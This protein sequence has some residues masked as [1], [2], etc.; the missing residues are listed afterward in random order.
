M[1]PLTQF[2]LERL[3]EE[4]SFKMSISEQTAHASSEWLDI[5]TNNANNLNRIE[6]SRGTFIDHENLSLLISEQKIIRTWPTQNWS[7]LM[8]DQTERFAIFEANDSYHMSI[9]DLESS[10]W[11]EDKEGHMLYFSD[12]GETVIDNFHSIIHAFPEE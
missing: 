9:L 3:I 6:L 1:K 8:I 11:K 5:D 2:N 4:T 7:L 10:E 12:D